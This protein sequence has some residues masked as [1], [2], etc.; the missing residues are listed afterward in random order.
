MHLSTSELE[1]FFRI[2][3]AL[4]NFIYAQ[5]QQAAGRKPKLP[6]RELPFDKQMEVREAF[7]K[8]P[9]YVERFVAENPGE[10]SAD[11]LEIALGWRNR[12]AGDFC[13]MKHLK[14]HSIFLLTADEPIAYGVCGL[15]NSLA[16]AI[17]ASSLPLF[18][19]AILLPFRGKIVYDGVLLS[20]P[21]SLGSGIRSGLNT[22]Y[23]EAKDRAGIV[24]TLPTSADARSQIES[25]KAMKPAK[26]KTTGT[27]KKA[28]STPEVE[29][30]GIFQLCV[31]LLETEP[32][33]WRRIQIEDCTLEQLHAHIQ[34]AMGWTN[35]HLYQFWVDGRRFGDAEFLNEGFADP[36]DEDAVIDSAKTMLS[37]IVAKKRKK[38]AFG[39]EYDFG[40]GW[41]HEIMFEGMVPAVQGATYPC[42]IAG[43][44]ACPPEDCGGTPGFENF[45]AAMSDKKHPDHR[46]LKDWYGGKFDAEK[47]DHAAAT[48]EMKKG[49]FDWRST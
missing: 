40:D 20:L 34:T 9:E 12:V 37:E 46:D 38:F 22:N 19:R 33:I 15:T 14:K 1:Q 43:E 49:L 41:Q 23:Q 5:L 28:A 3:S 7:A 45:L 17:P 13:L 30:P 25:G 42:C 35:S 24:T 48:K 6:F 11:D 32:A 18:T 8:D 4:N 29:S 10:L 39:Y 36:D 31:T 47:F 2:Q 21:V 44:R 26:K 27:T 16:D